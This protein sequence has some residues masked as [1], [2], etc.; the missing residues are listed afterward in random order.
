MR[1]VTDHI[2]FAIDTQLARYYSRPRFGVFR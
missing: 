2:N 1:S